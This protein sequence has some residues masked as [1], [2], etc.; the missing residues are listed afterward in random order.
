M[1]QPVEENN[2]PWNDQGK[3]V[4]PWLLPQFRQ[5]AGGGDDRWNTTM[6]TDHGW[7]IREHRRERVR[8]FHP[9][10]Q[11]TPVNGDDLESM[12]AMVILQ[13]GQVME[14]V[15]DCWTAPL[16][17]RLRNGQGG[18]RGYTFFK[19]R[20]SGDPAAE[21]VESDGSYEAVSEVF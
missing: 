8:P 1:M 17:A 10:H 6:M 9:L 20:G 18:W 11:S 7:L 14:I 15:Q 13:R 2:T 19:L 12:R 16:H 4:A 21:P 5:V 3:L